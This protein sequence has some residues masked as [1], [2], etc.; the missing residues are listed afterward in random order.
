MNQMDRSPVMVF[1]QTRSG[2][3]SLLKSPAPAIDH[4][5]GTFGSAAYAPPQVVLFM[6]QID[7]S[8]VTVFCQT[9]S[10]LPSALK[11]AEATIDHAVGVEGSAAYEPSHVAPFMIQIECSPVEV[12]CQRRRTAGDAELFAALGWNG[13][14]FVVQAGRVAAATSAKLPVAPEPRPPV[15]IISPASCVLILPPSG[16]VR[17]S[18]PATGPWTLSAPAA[19]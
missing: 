18:A 6:N 15:L 7:R 3:P 16:T 1:C 17:L 5:S 9:M 12:F 8:P 13:C 2:L 19:G 4:A 14:E 11:S 10:L